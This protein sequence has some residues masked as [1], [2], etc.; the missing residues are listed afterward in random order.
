[1]WEI[2]AFG[3]RIIVQQISMIKIYKSS[4]P[5]AAWL[6]AFNTPVELTER[7]HTKQCM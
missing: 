3:S 4:S 5:P 2:L 7:T 6:V 1:M